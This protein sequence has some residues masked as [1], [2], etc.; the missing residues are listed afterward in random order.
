[1]KKF[2]SILIAAS[3]FTANVHAA[4]MSGQEFSLSLPQQQASPAKPKTVEDAIAHANKQIKASQAYIGL[5]GKLAQSYSSA[6]D[7]V[8]T[9]TNRCHMR[10]PAEIIGRYNKDYYA[11]TCQKEAEKLQRILSN[12]Q[13]FLQR[14]NNTIQVVRKLI[15]SS[16]MTMLHANDT[17]S[18]RAA[19]RLLESQTDEIEQLNKLLDIH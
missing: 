3:L 11:Q 18:A 9:L 17:K 13:L 8:L 6:H 10:K 4:P 19:L 5:V 15:K 16:E 14:H 12:G 2:I 7:V 1:M